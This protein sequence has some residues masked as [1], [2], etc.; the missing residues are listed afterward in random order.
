[1]EKDLN[2]FFCLYR[3]QQDNSSEVNEATNTQLSC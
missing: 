3:A 2:T 1:M